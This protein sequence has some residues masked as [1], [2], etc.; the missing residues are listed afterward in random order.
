ME[1][2]E[3]KKHQIETEIKFLSRKE[4]QN[5]SIGS[6]FH[7]LRQRRRRRS[8]QQSMQLVFIARCVRKRY[9]IVQ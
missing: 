7:I 5:H 2:E 1:K 4:Y 9:N 6:I 8:G 3:M